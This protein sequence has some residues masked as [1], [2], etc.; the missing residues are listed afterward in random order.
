MM[1][2]L[3]RSALDRIRWNMESNIIKCQWFGNDVSKLKWEANQCDQ[4]REGFQ[5]KSGF[6]EWMNGQ[7]LKSQ[8]GQRRVFLAV[9]REYGIKLNHVKINYD[10]RCEGKFNGWSHSCSDEDMM[11]RTTHNHQSGRFFTKLMECASNVIYSNSN[12]LYSSILWQFSGSM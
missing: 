2:Y 8:R 10:R 12:D 5:E 1:L 4:G 6:R 11:R 3:R 9:E 7:E